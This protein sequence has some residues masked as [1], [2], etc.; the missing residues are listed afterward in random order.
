MKKLAI[1]VIL[2][3][4]PALAN[5][6]AELSVQCNAATRLASEKDFRI[7]DV[8]PAAF[9]IGYLSGYLDGAAT[10]RFITETGREYCA[11]DR[12]IPAETMIQLLNNYLTENPSNGSDSAR[13][14]IA[15]QLA[16]EYPCPP[17]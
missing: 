17:K 9:C 6:A 10:Q 13:T 15:V 2:L 3:A 5:T 1:C 4:S 12:G 8:Q 11:P 7:S 16:R 14:A